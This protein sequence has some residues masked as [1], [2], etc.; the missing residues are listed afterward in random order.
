[1]KT[2]SY[3]LT[4]LAVLSATC[5]ISTPPNAM[6]EEAATFSIARLVVCNNVVDMEPELGRDEKFSLNI[7]KVYCFLEARQISADTEIN[8]V[9]IHEGIT[10]ARVPVTL[11]KG[12]RWRTYSNKKLGTMSGNW[13]VEI[14]DAN[15]AVV[16]SV[17]FAVE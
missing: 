5:F 17:Q 3:F 8:F 13:S 6:A 12:W 11:K 14:H 7:G 1:M 9:W 4:V 16:D 15:D 10:Q 2:I